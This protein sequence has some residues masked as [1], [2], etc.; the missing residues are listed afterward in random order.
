MGECPKCHNKVYDTGLAYQCEKSVGADRQCDFRSGKII[1][2]REIEQAQM[3][4]LLT[5]GKTDL[6]H[7]FIS[8]KGRPF[9]AYLV[10]GGDGKVSFEFEPRVPKT[11]AKVVAK[12]AAAKAAAAAADAKSGEDAAGKDSSAVAKKSARP[13]AKRTPGVKVAAKNAAARKKTA[14]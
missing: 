8:K 10:R 6:L 14:A 1:L 2:Q 9:S 5:T 4:K 11:A 13:A 3:E 12:V 7:K